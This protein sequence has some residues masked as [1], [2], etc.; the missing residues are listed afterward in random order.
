MKARIVEVRAFPLL[1]QQK[2]AKDGHSQFGQTRLG[3]PGLRSET[4]GTQIR[5]LESML[6][7]GPGPRM[8]ECGPVKRQ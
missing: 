3:F 1:A 8:K 4:L 7:S 5:G 2:R 6:P